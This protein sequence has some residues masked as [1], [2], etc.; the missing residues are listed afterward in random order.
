MK[1]K[2][3]SSKH[4]RGYMYICELPVTQHASR[5]FFLTDSLT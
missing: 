5:L 1:D 4:I 2:V 3:S